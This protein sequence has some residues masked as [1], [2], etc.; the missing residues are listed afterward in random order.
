VIAVKAQGGFTGTFG[1]LSW[2]LRGGHIPIFSFL[3]FCPTVFPIWLA[4]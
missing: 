1:M 3:L 4:Y 2:L